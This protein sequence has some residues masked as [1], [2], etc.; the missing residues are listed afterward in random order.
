[1]HND[2]VN[3]PKNDPAE[4]KTLSNVSSVF[5]CF[6]EKNKFISRADDSGTHIEKELW[7]SSNINP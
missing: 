5:R 6:C 4:I 2:F 3:G 7:V 1:M